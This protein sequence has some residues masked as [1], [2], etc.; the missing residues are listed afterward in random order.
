MSIA[1][2]Q[3]AGVENVSRYR[4]GGYHPVHLNDTF[5]DGRYT[6]AH[7]LGFG[8][9]ST[10]WLVRDDTIGKY[11]SL[12]I[13]T[14][15]ASQSSEDG[16]HR[17][18]ELEVLKHLQDR[19]D[20]NE[21]GNQYV[22]R[23]LDHFDH[24]GPNGLHRCIITELLGPS[25]ASNIEELYDDEI[26]PPEIAKRFVFQVAM[27]I[28]YL[29]KRNVVHGGNARELT[30]MIYAL[31]TCFVDLHLGNLLLYSPRMAAWSA[32]TDVEE[33]LGKPR[34]RQLE[35]GGTA[36][37]IVAPVTPNAPTYTITVPN[38]TLLLKLC[39]NLAQT[40]NIKI[41]DFSESFILT[42]PSQCQ[43]T[44]GI[45]RLYRPLE[46]LFDSYADSLCLTPA[47]DIWTMAVL[48]HILYTGGCGLFLSGRDDTILREMV[49]LIGMLPEPYWSSWENKKEYFDDEG[50]W[51]WKGD[52]RTLSTSSGKF[53]KLSD[54]AMGGEERRMFEDMLRSMV[55]YDPEKRITAK[56]VVARLSMI[57]S[58]SIH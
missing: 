4:P 12:K 21:N 47:L 58:L 27:G 17:Y 23:M 35:L 52:P 49:R 51:R 20:E 44:V 3:Y 50:N 29:H 37:G 56:E 11:L 13:L 2:R 46:A 40:V 26:F 15:D 25:L 57:N 22:V 36:K 5:A 8:T 16:P 24:Q 53:L 30:V 41:C 34:Q 6:V 42:R 19:F 45:P 10:V 31:M 14:A 55:V 9:F 7:K 43:R 39:L 18:H 28:K 38:Q 54:K 1:Y 32:Q 48:F 33:Y